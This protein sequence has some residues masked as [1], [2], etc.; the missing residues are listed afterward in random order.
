MKRNPDWY[1]LQHDYQGW[2]EI[3]PDQ[4]LIDFVAG[5]QWCLNL[6]YCHDNLK[7]K[8]MPHH[9]EKPTVDFFVTTQLELS[10]IPLEILFKLFKDQ[11]S[12]VRV[13]GYIALLSYYINSKRQYDNLADSYSQNIS[14]VFSQELAFANNIEDHSRI[15]EFPIL[16]TK[17][18]QLFEGSNFI[19]VH[20][21]IRYF[22]WK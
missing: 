22:L 13:G 19:F 10:K 18:N 6:E 14:Q 11:Y 9:V 2:D 20:P 8:L 5:K 1:Q 21:N 4:I 12:K 15:I 17:N 3:A 16:V 7:I